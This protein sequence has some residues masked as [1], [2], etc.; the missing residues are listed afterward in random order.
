MATYDEAYERIRVQ[1]MNSDGILM[2][3]DDPEFSQEIELVKQVLLAN[4]GSLKAHQ[5]E[6]HSGT[7]IGFEM[8]L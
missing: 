1:I 3:L 7:I 5:D 2:G 4:G 6:Y 8:Q